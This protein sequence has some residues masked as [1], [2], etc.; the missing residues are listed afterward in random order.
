MSDEYVLTPT[1]FDDTFSPPI[2]R[3]ASHLDRSVLK[4]TLK[5]GASLNERQRLE[6]G[7]S[8]APFWDSDS[9]SLYYDSPLLE[10]IRAEHPAKVT[11]FP[12]AGPDPNGLSLDMLSRRWAQYLRFGRHKSHVT[13][14]E[15]LAMIPES[16]SLPLTERFSIRRTTRARF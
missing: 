2:M 7:L 12:E 5:Y 9:L 13:R 14:N 8:C 1:D 16:Q 10:A 15:T 6:R 4:A 3:A 11:I